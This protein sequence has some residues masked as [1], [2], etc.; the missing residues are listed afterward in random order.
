MGILHFEVQSQKHP[1]IPRRN[2]NSSNTTNLQNP[3]SKAHASNSV[4]P[5]LGSEVEAMQTAKS[6]SNHQEKKQNNIL[7]L[8]LRRGSQKIW[9][10]NPR[11]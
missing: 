2:L 8:L 1:A 9:V 10:K 6:Q 7:L 4:F 11:N 5:E 3:V